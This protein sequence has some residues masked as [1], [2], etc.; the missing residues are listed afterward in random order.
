MAVHSNGVARVLKSVALIEIISANC[1]SVAFEVLKEY[2][3]KISS[4]PD[5]FFL[6]NP[7]N[8]VRREVS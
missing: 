4:L 1:N 2:L 7:E 5:L 3:K 6:V 8:R